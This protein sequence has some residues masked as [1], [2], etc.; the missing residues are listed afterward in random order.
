VQHHGGSAWI[1]SA[2]QPLQKKTLK[3]GEQGHPDVRQERKRWGKKIKA[4]DHRR[5]IFIDESGAKTN[6]TRLYGRAFDGRRV[7]DAVPHGHW[8]TTTMVSAIGLGGT[9][10]PFVF[11]GAMDA[12]VF[13][14]YAERVL[15]PE[16]QP[17]DIVV[18]DN[19]SS[20]K[21]VQARAII[22]STGAVIWDLPPYSPDFNPIEPM[23]SKVKAFLRKTKA[24][25]E[26]TLIQAIAD[27][28]TTI[29]QDDCAGWF[30]HCGYLDGK[31]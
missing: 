8:C 4:V 30:R 9:K 16:L 11:G 24:R 18:M 7:C 2:W 29:T 26:K 13:R 22:E 20:H 28:L 23:W 10:A 31:S 17:G 15:V 21:D 6:M 25:T 12:E 27:A 3:A 19:L 5:L 1:G 14:I